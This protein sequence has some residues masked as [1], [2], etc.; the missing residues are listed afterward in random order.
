MLQDVNYSDHQTHFELLSPFPPAL[1]EA[2]NVFRKADKPQLGSAIRDHARDAILQSVPET[3]CHV[4]DGGS[5]LHRVP[6]KP[7]ETYGRIAESYADFTIR[8]YGSGAI[9]VFDGYEEGPSIK[10]VTHQRRRNIHPVVSFTAETQFSRKKQKILSTDS[11]K[12]RLIWTVSDELRK[13][14]CTVVNAPGDAYVLVVKT[15][16]EQSVLNL[17]NAQPVIGED[18]DL[19]VLLLYY[20]RDVKKRLYFRSHKSKSLDSSTVY[21]ISHLKELLGQDMCSWLLFLHAITGCASTS[22]IFGVGEKRLLSRN[23]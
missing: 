20:A 13:R 21:D 11:Y 8:H 10:D 3:E 15:A 18:T 16:V 7:G 9:V 12:Q 23:L 14:N 4:L 5:L 1:F 6:W 22:R 19:L 2:R 17:Y